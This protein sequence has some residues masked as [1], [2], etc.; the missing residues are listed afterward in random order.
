MWRPPAASGGVGVEHPAPG[1]HTMKSRQLLERPWV[2]AAMAMLAASVSFIRGFSFTDVF[3]VRDLTMFFW[4]RHLWIRHN[5]LSGA[6]PLWD[7]YASAGQP[8]YTDAL[9]QLFLPPVLLLRALP[10]VVGFNLIVALPFP[11]AALGA[12]LFLR[13]HFSASSAAVGAIAFAASGPVVSTGNFP[14]L[15]WSVAWI[16]WLLWAVDR[17]RSLRSRRSFAAVVALLALQMLSGEPVTMVGTLA[18]LT[19]YVLGCAE[20]R[21]PARERLNDAGRFV[22][23]VALAVAIS[24][25]QLVPMAVAAQASPRALMRTDNFWSLHPIWLIESALP[26]LFGNTFYAY[27]PQVPWIFPLNSGRDPFFYSLYVGPVIILLSVLGATGGRRPFRLFWLAVVVAA[28][29]LS[30]GD[31]TFVYPAL[32]RLVPLMRSFRFPVKFFL[33]T[34]LGASVLTANGIELLQARGSGRGKGSSAPGTIRAPLFAAAIGGACFAVL[35]GLVIIAP[36]S[37]ARAFFEIAKSVGVA[38]PVAGAA[39]LFASIPPVTARALIVIVAGGALAYIGREGTSRGQTAR[40][41]LCALAVADLL[42][43]NADLNPVIRA[44]RLGPPD[45]IASIQADPE[46]RFYFGGKFRGTFAMDDLDAP[47]FQWRPPAGMGVEEGRTTL[48]A[49]L[50]LTPAAW[51]VRELISYDL[52]QLWPIEQARAQYL[53]E[54]ADKQKRWQYLARGGVRYCVLGSPPSSGAAPIAR[55]GDEFGPMAVYDCMPAARRAYVVESALVLPDVNA[56]LDRLFDS[57][58]DAG[59]TVLLQAPTAGDAAPP[60]ASTSASARITADHANEVVVD[61]AAGP[62]GGY[63]I[64]L[65]SY[66]P[67]WRAEVDGQSAPL[68]RAN[69]LYRSVRLSPGRH[70]VT[71]RYRPTPLYGTLPISIAAALGLA[72]LTVT[73]RKQAA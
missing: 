48:S 67:F 69:A 34:S 8:F 24:A 54:H 13:R 11:L 40:I 19:A 66:D 72:A 47:R 68:R 46:A 64:L 31:H 14:N 22:A 27:G 41:A 43:V 71:F 38:D 33:F 50:G 63:L 59:S 3:Y 7:P 70:I 26:H 25:V 60:G 61:A 39:S 4:P 2:Y 56:Q 5:L 73:R 53:F 65:D 21:V 1:T 44:S 12:W 35:A 32:Q 9:N 55:V 18:L 16:P 37:G 15:S 10:A 49:T 51:G 36:F 17:D 30:F 52:P 28:T 57:S 58:F 29:M 42:I 20:S 6:F 23:A 45:W 62:R